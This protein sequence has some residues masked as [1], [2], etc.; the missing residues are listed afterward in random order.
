MRSARA[1]FSSIFLGLLLIGCAGSQEA[2]TST[3]QGLEGVNQALHDEEATIVWASGDVS[4]SLAY[5]RVTPDSVRYR[6]FTTPGEPERWARG[7]ESQEGETSQTRP[8]EAVKTIKTDEGSRFGRGV[9][10]GAAPGLLL[11]GG[12]ALGGRGCSGPGCTLTASA[13]IGGAAAA[14]GGGM[15]GGIIGGLVE[16]EGKVVYRAPIDHYLSTRSP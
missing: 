2:S 11:A 10:L 3:S 4:E 1:S 9:V 7:P 8:I 6:R 15:L 16:E 12:A 13:F 5:V 14:L